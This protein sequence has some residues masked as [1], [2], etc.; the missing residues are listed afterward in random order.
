RLP[1]K[2]FGAAA[3]DTIT[4][5]MFYRKHS[6]AALEKV[7]DLYSGGEAKTLSDAQVL[8]DS[9]VDGKYFETSEGKKRVLGDDFIKAEEGDKYGRDQLTSSEDILAIAKRMLVHKLPK[10]R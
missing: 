3:A 5:V 8:W 1:N 10:T 7:S 9:F 2:V 6:K 4:C